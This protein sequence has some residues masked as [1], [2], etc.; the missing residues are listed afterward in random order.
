M[1]QRERPWRALCGMIKWRTPLCPHSSKNFSSSSRISSVL[2]K[3]N[4]E[5]KQVG[6]TSRSRFAEEDTAGHYLEGN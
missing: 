6:G 4:Y 1:S 2:E 5:I 3:A